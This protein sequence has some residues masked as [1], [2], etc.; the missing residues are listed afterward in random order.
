MDARMGFPNPSLGHY[1]YTRKKRPT[2]KTV[3]N[4]G[5][6]VE[7]ETHFELFVTNDI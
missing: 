2:V 6:R 5:V 4:I 3:S 7:T 1:N